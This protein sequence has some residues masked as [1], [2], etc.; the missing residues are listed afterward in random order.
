MNEKALYHLSYGLFVLSCHEEGKDGGCIVNT[1]MQAANVPVQMSVCVSKA[2]YTAEMIQ[3]TGRFTLS[4]L[5]EGVPFSLFERFGFQTGREVDKWEGL[6]GKARDGQGIYY[7]TEAAN[8]YISC[9]VTKEIDLGSHLM[10]IAEI[11]ESE[12]LCE[13]PSMT[14]AYYFARVKPAPKAEKG[15]WVCKICG[16]VYDEEKEGIPFADLPEDWVCP[17]CKHPKSDF[18]RR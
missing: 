15:A 11:A 5:H 17:L 9:R 10:F 7:L 1:A 3:K 4:V 2:N 13:K 6:S 12:V 8:A 16:Y 14:Y 18:E